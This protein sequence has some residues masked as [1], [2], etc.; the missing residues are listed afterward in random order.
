MSERRVDRALVVEDEPAWQELV[1]EIL[2]ECGLAVDVAG[3][4]EEATS[5][6]RRVPHR[7]AVVDLALGEGE[8]ANRD[9]LSVLAALRRHDP[10]C[11]AVLLTGYATVELAVQAMGE[12]GAASCLQKASFD[13]AE[14]QTL[15]QRALSAELTPARG[16]RDGST[17]RPHVGPRRG[18]HAVLGVVLVV[19]DDAGWRGILAELLAEAGYQVRLCNGYGEAVGCLR[20]E[21]YALAVVDLALSAAPWGGRSAASD[22]DGYQLLALARDDDVVT[23]VVSGMVDPGVIERAYDEYGVFAYL[24]KPSFDRRA[25]LE[26]LAEARATTATSREMADL[27]ARETEVL[28]LL[29]RGKTNKEIAESLVISPNT[30]K[31]HLRAIFAKLDVHT[32]A[33]AAAKAIGAGMDVETGGS[34]ASR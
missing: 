20:R 25:F 26:T 12:Y 32:R 28:A 21:S 8:A 15:V 24:E 16:L 5:L 27:T 31:R 2:V 17:Q 22:L 6:I 14:F 30:V 11:V 9:G 18:E 13:R 7:L 4:T 34:I 19:E 1:G 10:G 3:T 29:A 33:A 23:I